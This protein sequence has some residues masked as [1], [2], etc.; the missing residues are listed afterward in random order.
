MT[1][2]ARPTL[3]FAASGE[4][5]ARLARH[6]T[7]RDRWLARMLHE[8]KVLTTHQI[9]ELA[10]PTARAANHRLL[11]LHQWRV[12]DRFQPFVT[13]GS[14]PMHYVLDV[15]GAVQLAYEDG[16]DPKTLN[17]RHDAALGISHSLQ[18]A[19]DVGVNGFFTS[20]VADSRNHAH[21][22][23]TW[24]SERRC[25]TYFGDVVRPDGYGRWTENNAIF[26][27]FLEHDCGTETLTRLADKI[28]RY[29]RLATSSGICTPVLFTFPSAR[30]EANAR[31]ALADALRTLDG[32]TTFP[33]VTTNSE[34]PP[35]AA[36]LRWL[37][38]AD[39]R[40]G[41]LRLGELSQL[42]PFKQ[43]ATIVRPDH[44]RTTLS[45][46]SPLPPLWSSR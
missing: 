41:R 33:V 9:A 45:P 16:L 37:P 35:T 42:W 20:L 18:L 14:A 32:T 11:T 22:L 15:A 5:H 12:V 30:R 8:H 31:I 36:S 27:F 4:H 1:A 17:Y 29:A 28:H 44:S 3:R 19:H 38:V 34:F 2:P 43:N 6:L 46:P 10:W 25:A 40:V 24:W 26:E 23:T 39:I 7:I 21:G 13:V